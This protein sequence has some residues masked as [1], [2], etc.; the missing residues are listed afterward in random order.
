MFAVARVGF[1]AALFVFVSF[2]ATAAEKSFQRDDLADNAIR[3]EAKIKADSG[4][5]AKPPVANCP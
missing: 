2:V 1:V 5:V 3:L 4:S